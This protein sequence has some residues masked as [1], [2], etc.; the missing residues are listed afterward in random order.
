MGHSLIMH[1]TCIRQQWLPVTI[2]NSLF[3]TQSLHCKD[4]ERRQPGVEPHSQ[5]ILRQILQSFAASSQSQVHHRPCLKF[6]T[7]S[8]STNCSRTSH[9]HQF[10]PIST[11]FQYRVRKGRTCG[12]RRQH[13]LQ[14][15]R[16]AVPDVQVPRNLLRIPASE[17]RRRLRNPRSAE[18]CWESA[19]GTRTTK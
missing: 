12:Q 8:C 13:A 1:V 4:H 9:G 14:S 19:P 2:T 3:K 16:A 18:G 7:R 15:Q 17:S 6:P 10:L 11:F 5:P